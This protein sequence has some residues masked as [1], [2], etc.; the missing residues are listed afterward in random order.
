MHGLV[1]QHGGLPPAVTPHLPHEAGGGPDGRKP[2]NL[3]SGLASWRRHPWPGAGSACSWSGARAAAPRRT[4][5]TSRPSS[6]ARPLTSDR[7]LP[8][9]GQLPLQVLPLPQP[10]LRQPHLVQADRGLGKPGHHVRPEVG[11]VGVLPGLDSPHQEDRGPQRRTEEGWLLLLLPPQFLTDQSQL[12]PV[13]GLQGRGRLS[14]LLASLPA[15]P[16]TSFSRGL[17][18]A[19][20][21]EA[22]PGAAA[23]WP[24]Y[25][26]SCCYP[27]HP[28]APRQTPWW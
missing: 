27:T 19:V 18:V 16:S 13:V 14:K 17:R 28:P 21:W 12:A 4:T 6:L 24:C 2:G 10:Q 26:G 15:L 5:F 23:H 25:P 8:A 1:P 22:S 3:D 7:V 9:A 11:V 20:P